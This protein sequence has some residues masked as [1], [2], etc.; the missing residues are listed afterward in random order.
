MW[1]QPRSDNVTLTKESQTGT[2]RKWECKVVNVP[3][4]WRMSLKWVPKQHHNNQI[5]VKQN[6]NNRWPGNGFKQY[7]AY[8]LNLTHFKTLL[9]C[10]F[11]VK[12]W[13]MRT[14]REWVLVTE[15][16]GLPLIETEALW[17][18]NF[19]QEPISIVT[20]FEI[21]SWSLLACSQSCVL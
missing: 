16:R 14:P 5:S 4:V 21:L 10:N 12:C 1:K 13:S 17:P 3:A 9:T 20:D 6:W 11:Q 7:R 15:A 18:R 2:C 8:N 19:C